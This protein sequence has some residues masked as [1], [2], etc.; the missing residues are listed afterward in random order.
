M[1][2]YGSLG[3]GISMS[4]HACC[5]DSSIRSIGTTPFDKGPSYSKRPQSK[6]APTHSAKLS[7]SCNLS[8]TAREGAATLGL[9]PQTL[10]RKIS[11]A[12]WIN[13]K[14]KWFNRISRW[15]KLFR[16]GSFPLPLL[17]EVLKVLICRISIVEILYT[18]SMI[19]FISGNH[20]W[21]ENI[22]QK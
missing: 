18:M 13:T 16:M 2:R 11:K 15:V 7:G 12:L 17:H 22:V 8:H 10:F 4:V 21:W 6:T 19:S 5:H 9:A 3:C 20:Q 1:L 14:H